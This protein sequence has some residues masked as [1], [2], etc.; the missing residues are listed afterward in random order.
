[1]RT[2]LSVLDQ[3]PVGEGFSHAD[4]LSSSVDLARMAEELGFARF[5][6]AEHHDSPGFAGTAPE[7]LAAALLAST[8]RI[9]VGTGGVL[10][11]RYTPGKVA[12]VFGVLAS[13]YPGRVDMGL[14]RAGGPAEDY[15][16]R[17]VL[18]RRMLGMEGGPGLPG[19]P[20]VPPRM[21]LLGAGLG[22]AHLAGGLGTEFAFA[23]FLNPGPAT[24]AL[25]AYRESVV[26]RG[27]SP[28]PGPGVLAVRAVAAES[29]AEAEALA[30]SVLL[31]RSRKDLGEDLPL[32]APRTARNHRWTAL[33]AERAAVR[34]RALVWGTPE[35]V[36]ARLVRLAEEHGVEEVMVNTL[37]CDPEDR[38]R[39]YRLL[40]EYAAAVP[41][42]AAAA[43]A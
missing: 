43:G 31:W 6:V 38:L 22:S 1:M 34:G 29:E 30:Q 10:L 19:V 4:A 21:W 8:D 9:T 5:W 40:A 20:P 17:V 12:E 41:V 16:E 14:G 27:G 23:H 11:P 37:A 13:L 25:S 33:E 42:E 2:R 39:S 15:P 18:L 28:A 26:P 36:H 24:A 3:S 7:V 32:P 35:R